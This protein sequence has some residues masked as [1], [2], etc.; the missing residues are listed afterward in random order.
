MRGINPEQRRYH[1]FGNSGEKFELRQMPFSEA[2]KNMVEAQTESGLWF[3]DTDFEDLIVPSTQRLVL[4]SVS[5]NEPIEGFTLTRD[6][7]VVRVKDADYVLYSGEARMKTVL[8]GSPLERG[9]RFALMHS[10]L[11]HKTFWQ[12]IKKYQQPEPTKKRS[13]G[14]PHSENLAS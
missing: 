6:G 4:N 12:E 9:Q 11:D 14:R 7:Y 3:F 13:V 2:V 5:S 1:S 10:Y 8:S